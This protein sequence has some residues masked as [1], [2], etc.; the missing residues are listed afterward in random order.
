M[1]RLFKQLNPIQKV[2][3]VVVLLAL[4]IVTV[5]A[6]VYS[7]RIY[8][9][10][11]PR[12]EDLKNS[13]VT[14]IL[15]WTF[16]FL[17]AFPPMIG[18]STCVTLAGFIFGM[19]GWF[20]A[21]T[22]NV[23]GS[24]TSFVVCR[25]YLSNWSQRLAAQDTRIAAFTLVVQHDGFPLL[26]AIRLCPL[27]YALSNCALSTI[28]SIQPIPFALATAAATPKLLLHVFVGSRLAILA[29]NAVKDESEAM[30]PGSKAANFLG[31]A[32]SVI[33][34]AATG[35]IIYRRTVARAR[36]L[37]TENHG[38]PDGERRNGDGR[39]KPRART[40]SGFSANGIPMD[41]AIALTGGLEHPDAF[42]DEAFR[43]DDAVEGERAWMAG[44]EERGEIDFLQ[45]TYSDSP[46]SSSRG[47]GRSRGSA[48]RRASGDTESNVGLL[49]DKRRD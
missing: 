28:Q 27:P 18:Y 11:A 44:T 15:L 39:A 5:V 30:D 2:L 25:R 16:T 1:W 38:L 43:D 9:W 13:P 19:K 7:E 14:A 47:K 12:A 34:G 29:Q 31:I 17:S 35:W 21:S 3:I 36:Q 41:D 22:A 20:I 45:R 26:C 42:A 46:D 24:T 48:G 4:N 33:I 49:N 23:I 10:M 6:L 40:A 37:E 8:E 32:A